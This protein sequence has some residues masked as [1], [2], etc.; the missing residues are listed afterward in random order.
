MQTF[1]QHMLVLLVLLVLQSVEFIDDVIEWV[2]YPFSTC[3][4]TR[5]ALANLT[6]LVN[7]QNIAVRRSFR[8]HYKPKPCL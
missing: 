7:H 8:F 5:N 3:D 6:S 1:S 4:P 2:S